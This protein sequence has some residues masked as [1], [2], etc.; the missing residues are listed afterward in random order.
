[1]KKG[2]SKDCWIVNKQ[3]DLSSKQDSSVG[4]KKIT[5][6]QPDLAYK[7]RINKSMFKWGSEIQPFEIRKHLKSRLFEGLIIVPSLGPN[8]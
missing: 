4:F 2:L 6:N 3:S 5:K 1:M 8:H 7:H